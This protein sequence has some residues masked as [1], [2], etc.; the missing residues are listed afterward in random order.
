M[1][2]YAFVGL[3]KIRETAIFGNLPIGDRFDELKCGVAVVDL[4]SRQLVSL[5]EFQAGVDEIFDVQVSPFSRAMI[6]G[7]HAVTDDANQIWSL[8]ASAKG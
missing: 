1:G 7:P 4:Q 8:P 3:S 6:S 2:K 5:L